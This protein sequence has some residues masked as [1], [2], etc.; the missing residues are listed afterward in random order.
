MAFASRKL[1]ETLRAVHL[2]LGIVA[3]LFI[4]IMGLS[5]AVIIFRSQ[6]EGIVDPKVTG[7]AVS[8]SARPGTA[9]LSAVA[10]SLEALSPGARIIRVTFPD[11]ADRPLLVQAD[12][13]GKK[14]LELFFDP[15]SGRALGERHALPWLDWLIDLHQNLFSG[16]TGRAWTGAIGASLFLLSASGLFSWL[17]GTRDWKRTLSLPQKGPWR[18]VNFQ[19][20]KWAGLWVNLFL[21]VVASTGMI[22]AWPKA[23]ENTIRT[24][25]SEPTVVKAKTTVGDRKSKKPLLPLEEYVRTA[26]AALPDGVVRELRLP[27]KGGNPVSLTV[28]EFGDLRGKGLNVV[29]LDPASANVISVERASAAP[30]SVRLVELANGIHKTE[31]GG[32]PVKIAWSLLGL[33]PALLFVSGVGIWWQRRQAGKKRSPVRVRVQEVDVPE[34]ATLAHK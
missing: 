32:L 15:S 31:L 16:K 34:M 4:V 13:V 26:T 33:L 27:S 25:M 8:D 5:G 19:G 22:L 17:A 3:G 1:Q 12:G 2:W 11:S 29:T 6:I 14:H 21:I 28:W 24:V 23:F 18:R 20:H 7:S 10:K 30:H 9:N